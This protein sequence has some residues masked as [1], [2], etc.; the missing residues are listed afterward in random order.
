[1][2]NKTYLSVITLLYLFL[3]VLLLSAAFISIYF[4]I[5]VEQFTR[6]P[7][8]ILKGHPFIGFI[9]NIGILLWC[10]TSAICLFTWVIHKEHGDKET[11]QFLMYSGLLTLLLLIDDLF[12][13]HEEIIPD[14][15]HIPEKG[16]YLGYL[17]LVTIYL[18][19]FKERILKSN[20][21]VL[22]IAFIFFALSVLSDVFLPQKGFEFLVE[23]GFKIFGIATWFIFF[24]TTCFVVVRNIKP[25]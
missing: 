2:R 13:F 5:P 25:R 4:N 3:S 9:S 21:P 12:M 11:A 1:M 7:V 14:Y 24:F 20:Y 19:R 10:S 23:D 8:V 15:L 18:V 6:D 16:V 22:L 17:I